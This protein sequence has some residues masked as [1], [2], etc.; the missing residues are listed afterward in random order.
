[1]FEGSATLIEMMGNEIFLAMFN[2]YFFN[3]L[4]GMEMDF[5]VTFHLVPMPNFV[6]VFL[7]RATTAQYREYLVEEPNLYV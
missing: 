6:V 1:M 5:S 4:K 7:A 2:L 3:L